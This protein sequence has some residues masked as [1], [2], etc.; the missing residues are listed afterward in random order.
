[1]MTNWMRRT[2]WQD[3]LGGTCRDLLITMSEL[4][5]PTGRLFS[6][7]ADEERLT[8]IVAAVDRLFDR[9]G[10]TIRCTDMCPSDEPEYD[11]HRDMDEDE[12]E[13]KEDDEDEDQ[14]SDNEGENGHTDEFGGDGYDE[15]DEE[16]S[17]IRS[18]RRHDVVPADPALHA[19]SVASAPYREEY[20][21]PHGFTPIL[22]RLIYCARLIFIEAI[23]PRYRHPYVD[24]A[25]R[26][27]MVSYRF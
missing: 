7:A 6:S 8:L 14:G 27:D 26:R 20:L 13:E 21:R 12:D 23:L 16:S 25:F 10:E 5:A 11:E 19:L 3:L 22:S 4:P 1:M 15:S 17:T 2:G 18:P 9:Y 24:I